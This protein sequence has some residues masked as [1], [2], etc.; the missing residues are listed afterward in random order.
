MSLH[1]LPNLSAVVSL[2][3]TRHGRSISKTWRQCQECKKRGD[4]SSRGKTEMWSLVHW[5]FN[6]FNPRD[7]TRSRLRCFFRTRQCFQVTSSRLFLTQTR[8]YTGLDAQA[9]ELKLSN[10][11]HCQWT[12]TLQRKQVYC[13]GPHWLSGS[14][15]GGTTNRRGNWNHGANFDGPRRHSQACHN[16]LLTVGQW[17]IQINGAWSMMHRWWMRNLNDEWPATGTSSVK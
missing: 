7:L 5:S 15:K 11:C 1:V 12:N 2:E 14:R 8:K 17:C 9:L 13:Q 4:Y 3:T 16:R 6:S 10:G